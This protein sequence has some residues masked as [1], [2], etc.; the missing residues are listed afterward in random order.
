MVPS[1][2][3]VVALVVL[4]VHVALAGILLAGRAES[5]SSKAFAQQ[6]AKLVKAGNAPRAVKLCRAVAGRSPANRLAL[7]LIA[8]E[9]PESVFTQA[10]ADYRATPEAS[11]FEE[12]LRA[13]AV[14]EVARLRREVLPF[15]V[16]AVASGLVTV[17]AGTV[18]T[19]FGGDGW[20]AGT[21]TIGT[22]GAIGTL[23]SLSRTWQLRAGPGVVADHLLPLLR[24]LEQM[25]PQDQEAAREARE[26]A[27]EVSERAASVGW[28][29][30]AT[31]FALVA[32]GV[33]VLIAQ[34]GEGVPTENARV[35]EVEGA[36]PVA[37]GAACTVAVDNLGDDGRFN[38]RIAVRCGDVGLYG[39]TKGMGFT[40]CRFAAGV[41]ETAFDD[42]FQEGDPLLRLDRPSRF[43]EVRTGTCAVRLAVDPGEGR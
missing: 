39:T 31:G 10:P 40:H 41:A 38:C 16:A 26:A 6:L 22:S 1:L 20:G 30:V 35:V 5:L 37:A 33:V 29:V 8:Q 23:L 36:A 19:I 42:S 11:P 28:I 27:I 18:A 3:T 24:P 43:V 12:R 34:P 32:P 21:M 7:F 2:L 13:L 15:G 4:A 9:L 25:R 14:A 17:A